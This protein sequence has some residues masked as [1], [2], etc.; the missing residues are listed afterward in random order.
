MGLP[1]AGVW[2]MKL[3]KG[4]VLVGAGSI[5]SRGDLVLVTQNGAGKRTGLDQYPTQGRYGAGVATTSLSDRTGRLA[6][7]VVGNVSDRLLMV[8]EK[9]NSKAVYVRS[10][11]KARRATQGR[12]LIAIRGR[13][14]LADLLI[15]SP[16]Q[17]EPTKPASRGKSSRTLSGGGKAKTSKAG[18]RRRSTASSSTS[19]KK[20]RSSSKAKTTKASSSRKKT[21][22]TS[23]GGKKRSTR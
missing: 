17:T 20:S 16:V 13:D 4:D 2:G 1:A 12:E 5:K 23:T 10:L 7:G 22:S 15:L 18:S 8:S 6:V 21:A 9:G 14:R 3:A 11:P 19:Q